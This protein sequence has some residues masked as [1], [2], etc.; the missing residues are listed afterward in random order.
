MFR[1]MRRWKQE[2]SKEECIL[3]LKREKRAVLALCG[4]EDYPYALPLNYLYRESSG[5]L[6][7]HG[8]REGYKADLLRKN[9]KVSLCV[10]ERGEKRED[11]AYYVRSVILFGRVGIMEDREEGRKILR[12]LGRKYYPT[13]QEVEEELRKS[14]ER[15][16]IYELNIEHMTGKLVHER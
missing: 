7:F 3:L 15:T 4:E 16:R 2:I 1:K 12:E 10:T 8:A 9:E 14:F 5:K 13:E 6:Y 11:W